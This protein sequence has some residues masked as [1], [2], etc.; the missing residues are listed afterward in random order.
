[1]S[2]DIPKSET[3]AWWSNRSGSDL[4]F[5]KFWAQIFA[6]RGAWDVLKNTE[7][8]AAYDA[9]AD[10]R[11]QV[12]EAFAKVSKTSGVSTKLGVTS[13]EKNNERRCFEKDF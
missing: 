12:V 11:C 13:L 10:P 7:K 9:S 1:M 2:H 6:A 4:I 3:S 8:R 5:F